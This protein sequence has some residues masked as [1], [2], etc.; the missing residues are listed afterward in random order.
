MKSELALS[1]SLIFGLLMIV[2]IFYLI[3]INRTLLK[4]FQQLQNF[5]ANV[6]RG[7]LDIPLNMDREQLLWC[8][9]GKF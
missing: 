6:A 8:V 9:H 5:A 3:Y 1:I 2:S 7:N 4:P